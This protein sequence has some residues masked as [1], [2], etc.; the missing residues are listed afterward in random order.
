M[1][2]SIFALWKTTLAASYKL[3]IEHSVFERQANRPVDQERPPLS[4]ADQLTCTAGAIEAAA[5]NG[6]VSIEELECYVYVR[7]PKRPQ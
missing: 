6:Q 2:R 1:T 3:L 4:H 5:A 7:K